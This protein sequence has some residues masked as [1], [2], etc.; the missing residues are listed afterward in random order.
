[1]APETLV[2]RAEQ[3]GLDGVAIT[4]HNTMKGIAPARQA[5]AGDL[6]V[7]PGEEIDT[8]KGQIIG[9]FLSE[10]IEAWQSPG[11]VINQIHEQGGVAVAPHPF[12]AMREGL[13][14]I[15]EHVKG[16]DAIETVNSRCLRSQ[17]NE[18]A[19]AFAT[20][21][22]LPATGGSDAHF[23]YELGTAFTEVRTDGDTLGE[24]KQALLAGRMAPKGERGSPLV[25]AG[26]KSVKLY[27][28]VRQL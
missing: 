27:N 3:T 17:Y 7:I 6:I 24:A 19:T 1:M 8:P 5:T 22:N 10:P 18:R 20:E 11:V 26:T 9:L 21:H 2:R 28:R 14:T 13:T 16:L 15:D 12:D 25:H 23:A 4:D